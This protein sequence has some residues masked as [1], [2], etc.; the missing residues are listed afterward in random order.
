MDCGV[1]DAAARAAEAGVNATRANT[2]APRTPP[3]T[4]AAATTD[5]KTRI[6]VLFM[7]RMIG[8]QPQNWLRFPCEF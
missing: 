2:V 4:I 3:N 1:G 8:T 6:R 7:R 5:A